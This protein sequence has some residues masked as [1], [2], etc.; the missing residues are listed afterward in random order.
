MDLKYSFFSA[1]KR[2]VLWE[3]IL[4]IQAGVLTVMTVQ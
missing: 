3:A 4:S 1:M 2:A